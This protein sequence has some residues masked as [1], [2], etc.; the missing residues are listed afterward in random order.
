M[1][2]RSP[3]KREKTRLDSV[4][5]APTFFNTSSGGPGVA[6][7]NRDKWRSIRQR[8]SNSA[9]GRAAWDLLALKT[10]VRKADCGCSARRRERRWLMP[11]SEAA[12]T[13]CAPIQDLLAPK[14]G[15]RKTNCGC[16]ARRRERRWLKPISE[17]ATTHCAPIP[18]FPSGWA[19]MRRLLWRAS[20][21]WNHHLLRHSSRIHPHCGPTHLPFL[22]R[23][24]P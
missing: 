11:I 16:S 19:E 14:T 3:C 6:A 4:G 21:K 8:G 23:A 18:S 9:F 22:G 1:R 12:T 20:C 7:T 10:S 24:G 15:V 5:R 17:A 2:R 13:H